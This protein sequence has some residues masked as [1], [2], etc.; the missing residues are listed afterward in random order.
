MGMVLGMAPGT[1]PSTGHVGMVWYSGMVWYGYG[2]V[3]CQPLHISVWS[4]LHCTVKCVFVRVCAYRQCFYGN[5][6]QGSP[7]GQSTLPELVPVYL[8]IQ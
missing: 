7:I 4:S 6:S 1:V 5:G 8:N 2:L 3:W